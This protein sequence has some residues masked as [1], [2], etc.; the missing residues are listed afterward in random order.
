M[1]R[2]KNLIK[3]LTK[4]YDST[5]LDTMEMEQMAK[6]FY[7]NLFA[8][9]GVANMEQVLDHV[10]HKVTADMNASLNAPYTEEEVKRA[11]FQMFPTKAPGP[12]RFPAHFFS[13]TG[14][15]VERR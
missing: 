10:P 8:S 11:L 6:E 1:R 9:K 12:D 7:N 2:H 14:M 5:T 3:V 15:Y 4:L 13:V